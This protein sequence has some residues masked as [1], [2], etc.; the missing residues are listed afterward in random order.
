MVELLC[1]YSK[2]AKLSKL[3]HSDTLASVPVAPQRVHAARRRLPAESIQQLLTDYQ[4]G[5]PSTQLAQRY[6]ISKGAVLRLLR[7]HRVPVRL[8]RIT[9]PEVEQAIQ[10]YQ[11][12]NPLAA[13]GVKLG[14]DPGTVHRALRQAGVAMRDCHGRDRVTS[15]VARSTP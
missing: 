10:L 5:V 7:E 6:G 1:R 15:A 8:Q 3:C 9:A 11:A 14:Y 13:V 2:L 4:A 12:G